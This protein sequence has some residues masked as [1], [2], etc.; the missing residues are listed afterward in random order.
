MNIQQA[1]SI[2][3]VSLLSKL[4]FEPVPGKGKEH[5]SW[6]LSPTRSTERTASFHVDQTRNIWYDFGEA[7][8]GNIIDFALSYRDL[9]NVSE[10]LKWLDSI[11]VGM[12]PI[13]PVTRTPVEKEKKAGEYTLISAKPIRHPALLQ[14]LQGRRIS[15]AIAHHYLEEIVYL[16]RKKNRSYFALGFCN[17]SGGYEFR[18]KYVKGVVGKKD[19]AFIEGKSGDEIDVF[20][21]YFNFLSWL[22]M[23]DR[24]IPG[25]DT[26]ILNGV[27][28]TGKMLDHIIRPGRYQKV[29]SWY[30]NDARS[31]TGDKYTE[32]L[33]DAL[34]GTGIVHQDMRGI[35]EG[36]ND[37]NDKL[38]GI[39]MVN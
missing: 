25:K 28:Q 26:I 3:L 22:V 38:C 11:Y 15:T 36:Y 24:K 6:Y 10:A 17:R 29:N 12:E 18:N 7:K 32:R 8:G 23:N 34:L 21:G 31:K 35:Y 20:E 4:G 39:P 37:L 30:D 2:P 1:R 33:G 5:E 16:S 19:L 14:Y 9:D 13:T 27:G